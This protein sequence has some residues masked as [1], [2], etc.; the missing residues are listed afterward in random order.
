MYDS[1]LFYSV[2][3]LTVYTSKHYHNLYNRLC[4]N[5]CIVSNR[6]GNNRKENTVTEKEDGNKETEEYMERRK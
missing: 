3:Y 2:C 1:K 6:K 4:I 5:V